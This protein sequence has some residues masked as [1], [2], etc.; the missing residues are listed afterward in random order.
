M[1]ITVILLHRL[2]FQCCSIIMSNMW[3]K[4]VSLFW[5]GSSE[6][7]LTFVWKW[8]RMH[9]KHTQCIWHKYCQEMK[10]YW[11]AQTVGRGL[12]D[13]GWCPR[14]MFLDWCYHANMVGHIHHLQAVPFM[15]W[16]SGIPKSYSLIS[17]F[18]AALH[19]SRY[20]LCMGQQANIKVCYKFSKTTSETHITSDCPW[21]WCCISYA[22]VRML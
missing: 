21:K 4:H 13:H 15:L 6:L 8:E 9:V 11:L 10:L 12:R 18:V 5:I 3:Q 2:K 19:I 20:F 16:T 22:C 7:T 17:S 1:K 14:V